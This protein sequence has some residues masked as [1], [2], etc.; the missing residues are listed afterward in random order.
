MRIKGTKTLYSNRSFRQRVSSPTYEVDSPT[1]N[2]SSPTPLNYRRQGH[3]YPYT[4][5][6][7]SSFFYPLGSQKKPLNMCTQNLTPYTTYSSFFHPRAIQLIPRSFTTAEP[8]KKVFWTLGPEV[9]GIYTNVS[10][11]KL[12]FDVGVP[13]SHVGEL[14]VTCQLFIKSTLSAIHRLSFT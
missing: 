2:V 1:S 3:F 7:Y 11:G 12:T 4:H 8:N 5:F 10:V 13:T 14:V 6:N 9:T